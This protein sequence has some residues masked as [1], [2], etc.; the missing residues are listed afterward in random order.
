[1]KLIFFIYTPGRRQFTGGHVVLHKLIQIID[2]LGY[3]VWS[4]QTPLFDCNCKIIDNLESIKENDEYKIVAVYPEQIKGN[5][6]N[7]ENVSRW[8]LYHTDPEIEETWSNTDYFFKYCEGFKTK[9]ET[10]NSLTIIDSKLEIFKNYG[11]GNKRKGYCHI[12]KKKYPKN[13]KI[14]ES[15]ESKNLSDFT[16]KGGFE[17]LSE[18]FNKHEFF[19]TYDDATYYS[20]LSAMCGCRSVIINTDPNISPDE[21]RL[22]YPINKFGVA[23]GWQD[24]KHADLTRDLT[25]PNIQSMEKESVESVKKFINFWKQKLKIY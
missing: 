14:L 2:E 23:Y 4:N 12:N 3:E 9:R 17:Y 25:T 19:I 15:L 16:E 11:L 1:M 18:E 10:N 8:I 22:K 20:V 7:V 13:E 5:P 24:L 21:Y 6:I